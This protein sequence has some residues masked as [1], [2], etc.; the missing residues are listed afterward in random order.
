MDRNELDSL[1][2]SSHPYRMAA[3]Y[4]DDA[5]AP[6]PPGGF[7]IATHHSTVDSRDLEVELCKR[8]P[9]IGRVDVWET[10][11]VDRFGRPVIS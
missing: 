1:A 6:Y 3:Y 5:P 8:R 4:T 7:A 10:H 11:M 2:P 9:E